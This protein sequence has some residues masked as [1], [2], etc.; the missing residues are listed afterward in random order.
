MGEYLSPADGL[1]KIFL[2]GLLVCALPNTGIGSPTDG[3][4]RSIGILQ[5]VEQTKT[6]IAS[7]EGISGLDSI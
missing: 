3:W 2:I 5:S 6:Q 4:P 1:Q 7:D